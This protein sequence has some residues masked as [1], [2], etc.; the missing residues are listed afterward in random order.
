MNIISVCMYVCMLSVVVWQ[1]L[2]FS[3]RWHGQP[4]GAGE[5]EEVQVRAGWR[6]GG[7]GAG[8][9]QHRSQQEYHSRGRYV[10]MYVRMFLWIVKRQFY[11]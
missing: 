7:A 9:C 5:P 8:D 1:W 6:Q 11:L 3:E 4:S 10:C 2:Q